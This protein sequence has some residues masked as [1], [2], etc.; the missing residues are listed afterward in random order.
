MPVEGDR[1]RISLDF[2]LYKTDSLEKQSHSLH[3]NPC[4]TNQFVLIPLLRRSALLC[5]YKPA[6][7]A[8]HVLPLFCVL[9][10]TIHTYIHTHALHFRSRSKQSVCVARYSLDIYSDVYS[11]SYHIQSAPLSI[12][13]IDHDRSLSQQVPT[14][15]I[16]YIQVVPAVPLAAQ[17]TP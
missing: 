4:A 12:S 11:L 10:P 7:C 3:A 13:L 14:A 15:Y 16:I 8:D 9:P 17:H 2:I 1:E 6:G 5:F